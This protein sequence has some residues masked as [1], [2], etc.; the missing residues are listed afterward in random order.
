MIRLRSSF[1]RTCKHPVLGP[2]AILLLAV[3]LSVLFLH[4]AHEGLH[5]PAALD[6]GTTFCFGLA[7]ILAVA[8]VCRSGVRPLSVLLAGS[9]ER[10]PPLARAVHACEPLARALV[11]TPLRR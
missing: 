4:V 8:V 6:A 2:L 11:S 1:E 7:A 5:A 3:L 10:G 9:R